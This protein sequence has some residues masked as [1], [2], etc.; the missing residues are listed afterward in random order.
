M[1]FIKPLDHDLVRELAETHDLLVSIEENALIGGAGS[2]VARSLEG[3]RPQN[4]AAAPRP[5]G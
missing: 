3:T 4:P 5:A 1:R 2:E